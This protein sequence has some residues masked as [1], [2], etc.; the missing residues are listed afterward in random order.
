MTTPLDEAIEPARAPEPAPSPVAA[1]EAGA[2][3]SVGDICPYLIASQGAWRSST[4]NRDHRC[5]AV[6]PAAALPSDKQR[7]LCLTAEHAGCP[8]FRAARAARAS[9][10]APGVDPAVVASADAAR[11]PIARALPVV[12]EQ[13]WLAIP[14]GIGTDSRTLY[15]A[16]LVG[17]MILA[18]AVVLVARLS[19]S[20]SPAAAPSPAPPVV[21]SPSPTATPRPTPLPTPSPSGSGAA[22]SGSG[23]LPP[24]AAPSQALESQAPAVRTTYRVQAGDTLVGIAATFGTTVTAIRAVNGLSDANLRIGQLLKIPQ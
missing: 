10:L 3:I 12:L 9:M 24:S 4:P 8:A 17:L 23:E 21:G 6:D 11:R 14:G 19:A 13:P 2:G 18:F 20:D 22:P 15:Q 7:T 5:T 1:T 16:A